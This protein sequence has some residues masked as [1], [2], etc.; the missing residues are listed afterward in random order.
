MRAVTKGK[1]LNEEF[2]AGL[3][4]Q[5][6]SAAKGE[7]KDLKNVGPSVTYKLRDKTGQAREFQNYMQPVTLDGAQVYLAGMRSSPSEPFSYLRIPADDEYSVREWMRLRAALADPACASS[8]PRATPS[9]PCRPRPAARRHGAAAGRLGR[10]Q[11]RPSS[12]ATASRAV[13]W[14][15]RS[16]SKRSRPPSR[17]KPPASS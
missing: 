14:P 11:P 2:A 7:N 6:G 10:A 15:C 13:T 3:D 16:S 17:K 12:P 1:S 8:P 4:K 9:A 5:L